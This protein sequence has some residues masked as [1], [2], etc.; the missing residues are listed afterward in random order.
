MMKKFLLII[1]VVG[2]M[3]IPSK[4]VFAASNEN[5][6][7][8]LLKNYSVVTFGA[9]NN[10]STLEEYNDNVSGTNPGE[11]NGLTV[12]G[13]VLAKSQ[14]GSVNF[15]QM[16]VQVINESNKLLEEA[17]SMN[18]YLIEVNSPGNY[19]VNNTGR[20]DADVY[21][22]RK[23]GNSYSRCEEL[24]FKELY[25]SN[26]QPDE[27][28]IFNFVDTIA[29]NNIIIYIDDSSLDNYVNNGGNYTGNIIL[30]YPNARYLETTIVQG[31]IVAP[32]ADVYV[33]TECV[34]DYS[35]STGNYTKQYDIIGGIY[36][37]SITHVG[38]LSLNGATLTNDATVSMELGESYKV[39]YKD[40]T[41]DAYY[42]DY[43]IVTLL[44]NYSIISLG[45]NNYQSNAKL[46]KEGVP[47]GSVSVFHIAGPLLIK[48][49][50]GLEDYEYGDPNNPNSIRM[51][52]E[53]NRVNESNINGRINTG[54]DSD[55]STPNYYI[56]YWDAESE[57]RSSRND[58]FMNPNSTDY[59]QWMYH[60][61]DFWR[62]ENYYYVGS[63]ITY[64]NNT[65]IN[66]DRLY[67]TVVAE[68]SRISEGTILKPENG[69]VHV[70]IGGNYTIDD[71]SQVTEIVYDDFA[72]N[73]D[74]LTII[75]IKNSGNITLPKVTRDKGS[76]Y[77][78]T[79]DYYGKTEANQEYEEDGLITDDYHGNIVFSIP[80][81]TYIKLASNAPFAGHI[82]APKADVET[83][84]TQIAGCLIVNS[85]YAE[86]SS[87]LHFYPLSVKTMD[88]DDFKG[89]S[90]DLQRKLI[91]RWLY[92]K[93]GGTQDEIE[94]VI[95]GDKAQYDADITKIDSVI[96]KCE[97]ENVINPATYGNI[98]L[99]ILLASVV[100]GGAILIKK[101]KTV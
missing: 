37:N 54:W 94:R 20:N 3:I 70:K 93:L 66:Y 12:N 79:N 49:D 64:S 5:S 13:N 48:G 73:K 80:N 65:Y 17:K 90:N 69:V 10:N 42:G 36:A 46:A 92:R 21:F 89:L 6:L 75:T 29:V 26:Y 51:D 76:K 82:I 30:N 50:L 101:K 9:N 68:Q 16:Y 74:K 85:F 62:D 35:S 33:N 41:D 14:G 22:Y 83:A 18:S 25:I 32:K 11:I 44:K 58:L 27:L 61:T 71:V 34:W 67:D 57:R 63:G 95:V 19:L 45:K 23:S 86:D 40:F 59:Y 4:L 91:D 47:N 53:S 8:S 39:E 7:N 43:S 31:S 56:K 99:I 97:R 100:T 24:F 81:A 96:S 60:S 72:S 55:K 28:Y 52:L 84:E 38:D 88:C 77:I 2:L 87:E 98:L 15:D 78:E 1:I